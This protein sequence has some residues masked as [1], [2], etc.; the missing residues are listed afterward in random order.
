MKRPFR[1]LSDCFGCSA[2]NPSGPGIALSFV[3]DEAHARVR[4]EDC[5]Q[6]A[7]GFV[8][9]GLLAVLLDEAMGSVPSEER[10]IR[11]T[12]EM[13]IKSRRPTPIDTDL[14]CRAR[15]TDMAGRHMT[16]EATIVSSGAEDVV[17]VE[18]SARYVLS[19]SSRD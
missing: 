19:V 10:G 14:L 17:L 8:H 13:T 16:V 15:M 18:G 11:L 5:H 3:A 12:A 1:H 7:P 6:G 4:F 9:G 2:E